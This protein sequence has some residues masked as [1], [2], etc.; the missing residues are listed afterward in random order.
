MFKQLALS[1]CIMSISSMALAQDNSISL[2]KN[3]YTDQGCSEAYYKKAKK[4]NRFMGVTVGGTSI[5]LATVLPFGWVFAL[6][7]IGA[8]GESA[9]DLGHEKFNKQ[10]QANFNV[11]SVIEKKPLVRYPGA[12][13]FFDNLNTLEFAKALKNST[14]DTSEYIKIYVRATAL[15]TL[16]KEEYKGCKSNAR[17]S[18][19][20]KPELKEVEKNLLEYLMQMESE[21]QSQNEISKGKQDFANCL[22]ELKLDNKEDSYPIA[23][24]LLAQYELKDTGLLNWRLK[25]VLRQYIFI[26]RKAQEENKDINIDHYFETITKL[27][28]QKSFCNNIKKPLN[29]K[30]LT[31]EILSTSA[32]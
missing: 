29:R 15:S 4:V 31:K 30:S 25:G 14:S 23:D 26:F 11:K 12:R 13:Q 22:L 9:F 6:G 8:V 32:Q 17:L 3:L 1:A 27:D 21:N 18:G 28:E 16:L 5:A 7:G 19:I 10:F 24:M 2:S 20:S